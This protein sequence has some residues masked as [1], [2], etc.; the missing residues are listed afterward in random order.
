[1]PPGPFQVGVTTLQFDD[2]SR[3]RG[4]QTEIWY[5][6]GDESKNSPRNLYSEYLGR[7][8][9]PGSIDA[10]EG[11]SAIGG[12]RDGITIAELDS[13]WPTQSVRDA[14]PCDKCT[15]PWPLVIFSHGAGAFRASYI[16][17]TEFLAS[18]GFV[19]V[20]CDHPGCARYTQVDGKVIL[21]GASQDEME[22]DRPLDMLF[23]LDCMEKLS[24]GADSRFTGR[25][26]TNNCALTGM[27]FG[28]WTTAAVMEKRDPRVKAAIMQCSS[29]GSQL[30][31]K[32]KEVDI[33]VMVMLSTEDRV[34][35]ED[36]NEANRRFVET[37]KGPA[38][39]LEIKRGG[40]VSFTSG[41]LYNSEY[42]N[43]IGTSCP[44]LTKPGENYAPLAIEKQHEII[45]SYGLAF[46]NA[47]LR[48]GQTSVAS[49]NKYSHEYLL[50]NHYADEIIVRSKN[51]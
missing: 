24:G 46:L 11:S 42:G 31:E 27:S 41:D 15:Q 21:P 33:P 32:R 17:W 14:R 49:S 37:H 13:N 38:Y 29:V 22:A 50:E 36:R 30:A 6:A 10:A 20:A 26:D 25:I 1:M 48:T 40:H 19:V 34:L 8:V 45:N 47:H 12:Y 44:S 35:G 7:G 4:L 18:H 5:P 2:P 39:M 28:G 23:L 51:S 43:G 9:I 3:K 16:Y